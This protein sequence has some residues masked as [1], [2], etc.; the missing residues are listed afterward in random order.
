MGSSRENYLHQRDDKMPCLVTI[1]V[2]QI[3]KKNLDDFKI[4]PRQSYGEV[5]SKLIME[6]KIKEEENGRE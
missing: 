2:S 3:V 6:R 5:I 1:K 4:H